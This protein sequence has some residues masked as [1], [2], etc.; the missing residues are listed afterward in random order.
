MTAARG[1]PDG[2][3]LGHWAGSSVSHSV[4]K[5][6]FPR[7]R[8]KETLYRP[9]SL[10]RTWRSVLSRGKG[11]MLSQQ[12]LTAVWRILQKRVPGEEGRPRGKLLPWSRPAGKAAWTLSGWARPWSLGSLFQFCFVSFSPSGGGAV[13]VTVVSI[14][15]SIVSS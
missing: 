12:C 3:V 4:F 5:A 10:Q 14:C 8:V 6:P 15:M 1:V 11:L 9:L 2:A 13:A 7:K